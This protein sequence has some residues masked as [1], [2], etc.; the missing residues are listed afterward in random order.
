MTAFTATR[1][2]EM[3]FGAGSLQQL[4]ERAA[5]LDE[6]GRALVVADGF[7]AASGA[8]DRALDSLAAAGVEAVVF[9]GFAGEPKARDI[10]AAVEAAKG[11]GAGLVIGMGGGSALDISKITALCAA[12]GQPPSHYALGAHPLPREPLKKILIP[13][14]SGAGSEA[15]CTAIHSN[16]QGKKLW[17]YGQPAKA[18]LAILDP[19]LTRSLPADLTAWCGM[20]ALVHAFEAATSRGAHRGAQLFSFRA[21]Q[22]IAGALETAIRDPD[23][24]E[25][26]GDMMLGAFYAGYAIENCGTAIAHNI[27]HALAGL[28]P[29]HHGLATA[30]GF[31]ATLAWLIEADTPDMRA[32]AS[33]CG[34]A[35]AS[36]TPG[37][38]AE[39]MTRAGVERRLPE[40]FRGF[41]SADLA[42]E[43]RAE[44]NQPM[45]RSTA[46]DVTEADIDRIAE[47]V[48]ALAHA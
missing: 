34:C 41:A 16:D 11:A 43:M 36:E 46:R 18:D 14:T 10:A 39:L 44:E 47:Q 30:L 31:E 32:A 38:F 37:W 21:L 28:A 12:S 7:L 25:A 20:D 19:T 42:R 40:P 29:V 22:L 13:T 9:S 8:V 27:S 15:N 24:L 2:P 26:R 5:G 33:A 45:R 17:I 6:R 3:I 4:G 35:S 23:D 1:L 48:M